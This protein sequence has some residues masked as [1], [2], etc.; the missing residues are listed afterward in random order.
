MHPFACSC[1]CEIIQF[2]NSHGQCLQ[3]LFI[4]NNCFFSSYTY[5]I[6][7]FFIRAGFYYIEN[8]E[9]YTGLKCL[10]LESNGL[11]KIEHLDAQKELRCLYLHQVCASKSPKHPCHTYETS[12]VHQ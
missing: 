7:Y 9:E 2:Y 8:L 1:I 11:K 6:I 10:W 5:T 12:I 4:F 3:A